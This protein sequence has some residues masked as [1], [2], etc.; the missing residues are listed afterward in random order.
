M[1]AFALS[2]A[3]AHVGEMDFRPLLIEIM[4][5][6]KLKQDGLAAELGVSQSTV[7]RW[8]RASDPQEPY[9]NQY[10]AV[11]A[12]A[13]RYDLVSPQVGAMRV[14]L[15][16]WVS[17][18]ELTTPE[19]VSSFDEAPRVF[20]P[21]LDPSGRW[22]ALRVEGDSMDR[23][24]PP[25]SIIFVNLRDRRLVPNACYVIVADGGGATYKRYRSDPARWEPVSTQPHETLFSPTGLGPT[26]IGRVRKTLLEL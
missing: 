25:E 23:I 18:G 26:V 22:I 16:S 19:Q 6:A 7:S 24:S 13:E 5:A 2:Y 3:Q 8:M 9:Y 21:D 1:T 17:A 20:G 10:Q 11:M 4:R 14:P 12:L 15:I